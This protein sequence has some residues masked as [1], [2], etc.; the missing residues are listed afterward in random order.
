MD[1]RLQTLKRCTQLENKPLYPLHALKRPEVLPPHVRRGKPLAYLN[2]YEDNQGGCV[3]VAVKKKELHTKEPKEYAIK[4]L[5]SSEDLLAV[6]QLQDTNIVKVHE[7]YNN[8]NEVYVISESMDTSLKEVR[9]CYQ[10]VTENQLAWI[11]HHVLQGLKFL[12]REGRL[13]PEIKLSNV[14][15][16]INC[17]VKLGRFTCPNPP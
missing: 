12:F 5:K 17:S 9:S 7:V 6:I 16:N 10:Y 1:I 15:L 2:L 13:Y 8:E 14:L 3:I 4:T 11:V